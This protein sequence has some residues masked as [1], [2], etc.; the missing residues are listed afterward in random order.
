[1]HVLS[2]FIELSFTQREIMKHRYDLCNAIRRTLD[3]W[4]IYNLI[5]VHMI[6]LLS[7]L[8]ACTGVSYVATLN[9][10]ITLNV[11]KYIKG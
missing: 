11:K 7:L 1:M 5:I 9:V 4:C 8:N 6:I 2:K 3:L 10:K